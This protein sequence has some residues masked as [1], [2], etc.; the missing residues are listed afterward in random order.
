[1]FSKSKKIIPATGLGMRG[2]RILAIGIFL[3]LFFS[4]S[5]MSQQAVPMRCEYLYNFIVAPMKPTKIYRNDTFESEC[6][7]EFQLGNERASISL[8]QFSSEDEALNNLESNR[9]SFLAYNNLGIPQK[10]SKVDF[11]NH[12]SWD[13]SYFYTSDSKDNFLLLRKH[14]RTATAIASTKVI[15]LELESRLAKVQPW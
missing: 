7:F 5:S 15:L 14:R 8:E 9:R 11:A 10:F 6:S 2:F 3:N 4:V 12:K 13:Q 1:M